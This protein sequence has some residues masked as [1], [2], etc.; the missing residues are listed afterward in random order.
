MQCG[1]EVVDIGYPKYEV[2]QKCGAP[3]DV[4]NFGLLWIYD[5]GPSDFVYYLSFTEDDVLF[6]IQSG[7]YGT[8][9]GHP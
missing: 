7:R 6:H 4:G 5:F 1:T 8:S 9:T 3:T 2:R